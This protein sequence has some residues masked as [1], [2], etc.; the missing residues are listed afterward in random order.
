MERLT[1]RDEITEEEALQRLGAQMPLSEK[2]RKADIVID[3]SK[4][5][6]FTR[7]QVLSVYSD[8]KRVSHYRQYFVLW[9]LA[10]ILM[11]VVAFIYFYL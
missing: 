2:C 3:N 6:D 11:L 5:R 1:T 9:I 4:D 7:K 10:V 8:M